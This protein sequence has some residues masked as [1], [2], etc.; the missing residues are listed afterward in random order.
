MS[1]ASQQRV[2]YCT[3][4]VDREVRGQ[5]RGAQASC[6]AKAELELFGRIFCDVCYH[7]S[8]YV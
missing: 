2:Q 5:C 6:G 3:I 7:I 1:V 8:L 4:G